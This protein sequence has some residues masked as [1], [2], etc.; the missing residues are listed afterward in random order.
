MLTLD[1]GIH[2]WDRFICFVQLEDASLSFTKQS[3]AQML[4]SDERKWMKG[5]VWNVNNQKKI[6]RPV[7]EKGHAIICLP[8]FITIHDEADN[9]TDANTE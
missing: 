8:P 5:G 7:F 1:G 3:M 9:I 2:R 6:Q 4:G